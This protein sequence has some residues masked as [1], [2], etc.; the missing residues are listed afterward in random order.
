MLTQFVEQDQVTGEATTAAA[1][2]AQPDVESVVQA[3]SAAEALDAVARGK[4]DV[5]V[6]ELSLAD[7]VG[8]ELISQLKAAGGTRV[9]VLSTYRDELRVA[10][11]MRYSLVVSLPSVWW[12]I[13]NCFG[14]PR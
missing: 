3:E 10:E 13:W 9:L 4:F 12:M 7:R 1:R 2:E 14:W 5:A 11:A 8:T 6:V